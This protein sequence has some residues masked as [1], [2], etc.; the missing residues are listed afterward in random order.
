V[1]GLEAR[2]RQQLFVGQFYEAIGDLHHAAQEYRVACHTDR[3]NVFVMLKLGNALLRLAGAAFRESD[4]SYRSY[5]GECAEIVR[6]IF[7]YDR[8]NPRATELMHS[9]R[10]EFG[11]T[12]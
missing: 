7:R 12:V 2:C 8:D 5:A 3:G 10:Q 11:V 4:D 6:T 1:R 9:L